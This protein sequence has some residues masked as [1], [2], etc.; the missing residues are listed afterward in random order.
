MGTLDCI[1][2]ILPIFHNLDLRTVPGCSPG[3]NSLRFS[4]QE[5]CLNKNTSHKNK[6]KK[7]IPPMKRD[8]MCLMVVTLGTHC[9]EQEKSESMQF[10]VGASP[11]CIY[12]ACLNKNAAR[13]TKK[14]DNSSHEK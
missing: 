8:S 10:R 4:I 6:K 12:E 11:T 9:H 5:V 14:E 2:K 3:T 1:E 13:N 7:T